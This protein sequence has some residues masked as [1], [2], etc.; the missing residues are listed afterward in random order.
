[1]AAQLQEVAAG[2]DK[3]VL[4]AQ[5]I[6]HREEPAPLVRRDGDRLGGWGRIP[7]A[8]AL[9]QPKLELVAPA[10]RAHPVA[11]LVGHDPEQPWPE[12]GTQ[13]EAVEQIGRASCRESSECY[14]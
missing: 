8:E 7:R 9:G 6:D 12:V 4:V 14:G 3:A 1:L 2:D 10:R 5:G 11:S 13:S